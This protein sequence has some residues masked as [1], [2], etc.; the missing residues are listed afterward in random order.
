MLVPLFCSN[1][2]KSSKHQL[3]HHT[4]DT[5]KTGQ[6]P[7]QKHPLRTLRSDLSESRREVY[8]TLHLYHYFIPCY[9][10][11]GIPTVA[12]PSQA[13]PASNIIPLFYY[14]QPPDIHT[15]PILQI[16]FSSLSLVI[17]LTPFTSCPEY[18]T[19]RRVGRRTETPNT[20]QG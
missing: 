12:T 6:L 13:K 11:Y 9:I 19:W 5:T 8:H 2:T 20:G 16:H 4:P 17:V 18:N 7:G 10:H 1:K 15:L 3:H 14:A